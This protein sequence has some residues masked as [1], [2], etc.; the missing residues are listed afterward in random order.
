MK[1]LIMCEGPNEL[2][3]IKIL[4]RHNCLKFT[5]DDLL[6]LVPYHARQIKNSGIVQT[7]LNI[8][9]GDVTILRIGDG[10]NEKLVV[11]KEYKDK[12]VSIEKYCTKP[13]LEILLIISE[14]LMKKYEKVKSKQKAKSFAKENVKCGRR[15]YKND[16]SFYTEYYGENPELL[17]NSIKE[18]YRV[19]SSH[20]KDE[21]YLAELLK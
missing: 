8:Y 16:T 12:I 18:Y 17:V 5:D 14:G 7:A 4:L 2:E 20:S 10:L 11:P 19:K 21:H 3:I 13:E 6:G 9:Q 15:P 1:Y